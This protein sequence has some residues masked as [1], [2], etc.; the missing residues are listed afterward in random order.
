MRAEFPALISKSMQLDYA[1]SWFA[2][3]QQFHILTQCNEWS[4]VTS[5]SSWRFEGCVLLW[6]NWKH[7]LDKLRGWRKHKRF[8]EM[9]AETSNTLFYHSKDRNRA[10]PSLGLC[11]RHYAS[12][13]TPPPILPWSILPLQVFLSVSHVLSSVWTAMS[14]PIRYGTKEEGVLF[15]AQRLKL[16]DPSVLP[17]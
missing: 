10:V 4:M 9:A 1:V 12:C 6:S 17:F 16:A 3:K 5:K 7:R 8:F 13:T 11:K 2:P 15:F 14:E